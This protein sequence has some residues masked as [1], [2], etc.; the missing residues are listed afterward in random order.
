MMA[1]I[2][3]TDHLEWALQWSLGPR[4]L[5]F[6]LAVAIV[7]LAALNLR[8]LKSKRRRAAILLLR[9]TMV[10]SLLAV[11]M[12][13][14]WVSVSPRSASRRVAV[15]VDRSQS[16]AQGPKQTGKGG[17]RRYDA[18]LQAAAQITKNQP[19]SWYALSDRL[20]PVA[21][22]QRLRELGPTIARTDVLGA[23]AALSDSH[24]LGNLSAIVL[25]TDGLDNGQLHARN[26]VGNALD[27]ETTELLERLQVPVHALHIADPQ[28]VRDLAVAT[29]RVASF[30]FTRTYMP[31]AVDLE[32]S[33]YAGRTGQFSLV[34]ADNGKPI[35]TRQVPLA[36]PTRRTID[37]EFQPLHVGPHL[38]EASVAPLPDEATESNNRAWAGLRVVRD[39]TRVLHLAGH[40]SWDTRFLRTHLRGNPAVDLVSFYVM[41]GQGS[42][43]YVAAED[44]TLIPFP[45]REIFEESLTS[46]DL[47]IFQDFQ[48]GPFQVEQY[49]PQIRSYV[50]GG[51]AF[52][53][54]GGKQALSAGGYYGT[55]LAEWL[56]VRLQPLTGDDVGYVE[57]PVTLQLTPAGQG[58]PVTQLDRAGGDGLDGDPESNIAVWKRHT[59][60]GRNTGMQAGEG[61][62]VLVTDAGGRPMLAVG[63][64]GE[65]RSAVLASDGLWTWAF[66]PQTGETARDQSRTEYHQLLDQ[67]S[68][69]LLRDPD[70]DALRLEASTEPVPLGQPVTLRLTARTAGGKPA[71]GLQGKAE[72]VALTQVQAD[73]HPT[74]VWQGRTDERGELLL[75]LEAPTA[76]AWLAVVEATV[77]GRLQRATAPVVVAVQGGEWSQLQ[78]DDRLLQLLAKASGGQVFQGKAPK[79]GVPVLERELPELAEHM[80]TDLWSR[81]E[82]LIWLVILM[83][84]EWV[85]RRR[86]GLA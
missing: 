64:A 22:L 3:G 63:E 2:A 72:L 7:A 45:T 28:P 5:A 11:W 13:P 66:P 19:V 40:P 67:L 21:S 18:A 12:Q 32:V 33:G 38:L 74:Q 8:Q 29:V 86:W 6:A 46:F 47:V 43:A 34:L 61:G 75:S 70:L 60:L 76:G 25:V 49:L 71:V 68:A 54:L 84:G 14:T 20:E 55:A 16:M 52:L 31:V 9:T 37:L 26:P 41:V 73:V 83:A 80:H 27:A 50:M 77:D 48:F 58:H 30:G 78:P 53:V 23:L 36:G 1:V 35:V 15:V 62:S 82:V 79:G 24:R 56:P 59:L 51:G 39:R 81:P 85:L 10:A 65:G 42:G 17:Q 4:L 69:W 44:T 57:G